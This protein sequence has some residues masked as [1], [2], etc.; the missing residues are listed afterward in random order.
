M[1]KKFSVT[2]TIIFCALVVQLQQAHGQE[3]APPDTTW[4]ADP[5]DVLEP[6]KETTQEPTVPEFKE[7]PEAGQAPHAESAPVSPPEEPAA[8]EETP[9]APAPEPVPKAKPKKKIQQA[10]SFA[11][12][13][14]GSDPDYE[15][16]NEFHAI[17]KRFNQEPTSEES[18]EKAVGARKSETYKV[19][20]GNT[21]WDI[22]NT[23]FGDPNF[24]PKIWSLNNDSILNPHE[25]NPAMNI[26]FFPGTMADAPTVSLGANDTAKDEVVANGGGEAGAN[27]APVPKTH[28]K[29]TPVLKSLPSSLP[30]GRVGFF[31]DDD[32]VV[33]VQ[34]Q[35]SQFPKHLESLGYY[36]ADSVVV[37][38]G[39]IT[40]TEMDTKT[41]GDFQHV[42]VQLPSNAEKYYVAHK[43]MGDVTDPRSKDRKGKMV[44]IQGEIEVVEKVNE[45]KNI[46]RAIVRKAIQ[47]LEVGAVLLPGHI[48]MIDPASSALSSSAG[49]KIMGGQFGKNRSLFS[50][51]SLV[52]LNGGSNQGFQEG[53]SFQVYA[54]EALRNR[55]TDAVMNDRK[56]G[57]VKIVKVSPNFATAYV[58]N[59][60]ED[61]LTGDYVGLTSAKTAIN[62]AVES[63]APE[64]KE[65]INNELD[66]EGAPSVDTPPESGSEDLDLEL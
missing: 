20:K 46:Y 22:S 10:Q 64:S 63:H 18:W 23:F 32:G 19:Q 17:Y 52:F 59:A 55:Q 29:I 4:D 31:A 13:V 65:E 58:T 3:A 41:A 54:D 21:L 28:R 2:L 6:K 38:V 24:W 60:S 9:A 25:I 40:G 16:E 14:G 47:P 51:N 35:N 7:I 37:G 30:S 33:D 12:S 8:P 45:Q 1:N 26:Q 66:L 34:L 27:N 43:N 15:K 61:I 48:P 50:A 57:I 36:L 53:Q 5:L 56:I 42:Y 49:G 11:P 62:K 44:E 39:S